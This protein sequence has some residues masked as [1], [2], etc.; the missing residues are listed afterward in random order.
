MRIRRTDIG[1][2]GRRPPE[3]WVYFARSPK[4]MKTA[5]TEC[6]INR[7]MNSR[8]PSPWTSTTWKGSWGTPA[9]TNGTGWRS[10]STASPIRRCSCPYRQ[11]RGPE[12]NE[13]ARKKNGNVC[14]DFLQEFRRRYVMRRRPNTFRNVRLRRDGLRPLELRDRC[15][16]SVDDPEQE[17]IGPP[18]ISGRRHSSA[19][20]RR[21]GKRAYKAFTEQRQR[22]GKGEA[23]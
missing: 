15:I 23:L 14:R 16:A 20:C 8:T 22:K 17:R 19:K 11:N 1:R 21:E 2:N 3:D 5:F 6:C 18:T 10:Q 9:R 12:L 7:M 13:F 4:H